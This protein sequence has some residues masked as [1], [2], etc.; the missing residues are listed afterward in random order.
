MIGLLLR[1]VENLEPKP[2]NIL[3]VITL[4]KLRM[5]MGSQYPLL[6]RINSPQDIKKLGVDDLLGLSNEVRQFIID[7]VSSNP[8]HFGASLGVVELTVALHYVFNTPNDRII[9]DVGH[10]AYGHKILTG[11]R[12]LFH[13]NRKYGGISGFPKRSESEY[14]AFGTGHSSTSISAA[15]GMALASELKGEERQTI[16]VIGD[17]SMTAGLAF[18]G[19]NNGG[20]KKSNLLV[21]L[22][23]NNMAID[24]NVGALK[25]YLLDI[26]TSQT[27]NRFKKDVWN[28]LGKLD[29]IA[30]S[31]RSTIQKLENAIKSAILKQSNLF[32]SLG[33]RYFGPVDGHDVVYLTQ[34]L[35][36]LKNI[37]GPKLLHCVTVKGKGFSPAEK[38]QTVWHAPGLFDKSTG[39]RIVVK[40]DKPSPPRFQDVFGHTL[41]ELAEQ[42]Q[43]IVGI[44]PAM[45]TGCSMNIMMEKIPER[46]FDVGIAEQHAVTFAAGLAAEGLVPFCNIY[47]SFMQRAYDQVVHDAALQNLNVVFCLDRGGLVGDDGATHHG[48]FDIAYM[49]AIPNIT[50][51][52]PM[53]EEELRNMMYTAQQQDMGTWSIR[54]P[55]GN[56]VMTNWKKPFRTLEVGKGRQLRD[57]TDIAI[58]TLGPLGN[59]AAK[60]IE[61]LAEE[62]I[63]VAH[64]DMRF[65]KPIDEQLLAQ[66]G[67]R[68]KHIITIEDGCL[69]GGFGSAI[70]EWLN[71]NGLST[72]VIR[73]GI[74]DRFID[75]GTQAELYRECGIDAEGIYSAAKK[76]AT[77]KLIGRVV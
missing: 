58:L 37:P 52:S 34:V 19:L 27:Y 71:D 16:A 2:F 56:G 51:C 66:I 7:V 40:T 24:P 69:Q 32:E 8:G 9:W 31:T 67:K 14:D 4:Q 76:I 15:L 20:S 73:L 29:R 33:F 28:L 36:D 5:R 44:T 48:V 75:H 38:D 17:G 57:G 11:R 59:I 70:L 12:D 63:S 18:E 64:Y 72:Q 53:N 13:T 49:R 45:P 65:V 46:T 41:V 23:D 47:S 42:N 21:I 55:R 39:E 3:F 74:P 6:S 43:K 25:E 50:I 77:P 10:Q 60:A 68:F 1:Y 30:P 26:T 61:K 54:Y 35:N 62:G 22:N